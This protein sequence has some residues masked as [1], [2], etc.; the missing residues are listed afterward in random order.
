MSGLLSDRATSSSTFPA[1][2]GGISFSGSRAA[3]GARDVEKKPVH[4]SDAKPN[5]T[6]SNRNKTNF[7]RFIL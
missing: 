4:D 6:T 5:R 7:K 1:L 2:T 3:Q